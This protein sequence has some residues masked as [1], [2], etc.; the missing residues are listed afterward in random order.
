MFEEA[1]L[2]LFVS[3][4]QNDEQIE[5]ES[6]KGYDGHRYDGTK[7]LYPLYALYQVVHTEYDVS[8]DNGIVLIELKT[9]SNKLFHFTQLAYVIDA[10]LDVLVSHVKEI[11]FARYFFDRI[12]NQKVECAAHS[13]CRFVGHRNVR[14]DLVN[15]ILE[16]F[17]LYIYL[18]KKN[19]STLSYQLPVRKVLEEAKIFWRIVVLF[20][21]VIKY[22]ECRVLSIER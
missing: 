7:K 22:V 2:I 8:V 14:I 18:K 13:F 3:N 12:A 20:Q 5:R 11:I 9:I 16:R 19:Q 21:N 17:L 4:H 10:R 15:K 6:N 1:R